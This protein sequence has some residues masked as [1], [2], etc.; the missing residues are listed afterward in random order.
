MTT[1]MRYQL[2]CNASP[3]MCYGYDNGRYTYD[4]D[5]IE[6][7]R[8]KWVEWDSQILNALFCVTGFGLAPWRFRDLYYLMQYR[9]QGK[10][11]G[12]QRLA[13][14]HR[15]WFRLPGSQEL[16]LGVAPDNIPDSVPINLIPIPPNKIPSTSSHPGLRREG[17]Q[18]TN[19]Q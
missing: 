14:I 2:L 19:T 10:Y 12:L 4:C 1:N 9:I 3:A 15:G 18:L 6:G 11:E 8:R 13:G 5:N 7:P 16:P 17:L